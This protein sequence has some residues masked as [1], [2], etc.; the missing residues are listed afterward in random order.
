LQASR[1][2]RS[3]SNGDQKKCKTGDASHQNPPADF[4]EE[5]FAACVRTIAPVH[6]A[7][8]NSVVGQIFVPFLRVFEALGAS[9]GLIRKPR[10][11]CVHTNHP[12]SAP[13]RIL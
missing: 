9:G 3:G 6:E 7:K 12:S 5:I 4:V 13:S 2:L 1:L 11:D 10:S 8:Y